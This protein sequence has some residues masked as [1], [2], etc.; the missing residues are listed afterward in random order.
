MVA[1]Y[2]KHLLQNEAV[3]LK[4]ERDEGAGGL[5]YPCQHHVC[6]CSQRVDGD[7]FIPDTQQ[8]PGLPFYLL[9]REVQFVA[10]V[11]LLEVSK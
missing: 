1:H 4:R 6:H 11:G 8:R 10:K 9:S 3:Q 7:L 5:A 2:A